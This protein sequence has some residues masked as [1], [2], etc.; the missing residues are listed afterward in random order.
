MNPANVLRDVRYAVRMLL[1]NPGF[2]TIALLTFAVGIGINTAVFSVFNGVLLRPLPYPD[3]ERITMM[4][5]DN[6][7]QG[8]KED[9]GSYPNY[10][11][12]REQN[13]TYEH[14]A[15]YT[16]ASM[17]MTGS[18][19]PERLS[20]AQTTANFFA[21]MGIQPV[22][23]RV[24]NEDQ[25]KV[26]NDAVVVLSHGLWQRKFGGTADV[27]GKTIVLNGRAHEIIGVMAPEL[28]LPQKTQLWKPLAVADSLRD[29]RS[30]FWLP[31]IGKLKPG[32]SVQQAQTEIGGIADRLEKAYPQAQ[33]G[34]GAYI[35]PIHKQL[36]GDIER[37]LIVLMAAVGCVLLI[38]CANLGNL[39]LGR[40]AA[41][42]KELA[43]RTALGARRGRLIRQIVTETFVIAIAGSILGL[44]LAFWATEFFV[45]LGGDA[46][47]RKEAIAI[48][49]RVLMFT[50][51]LA[52]VSALLAGL[53]P[54][55]QASR[56][57]VRDHL[58]EGGREGG[59]GGSRRTRSVLIAAEMA[60][61]FILLAGAGVLVRT[62]W[63]ME[64][65]DRGF[66]PDHV[67]V[68]TLSLP[69]T[70]FAG[71]AE[72]RGF[73]TRLL[74]R[75]R[76][77]P[78]VESAATATGI[79]QPLLAN[80]GI[81]T[82]EG[83]PAPPPGQQIEYP[84]ETVSPGF[85][86]TLKIQLA[87]GRFFT[88]QDDSTAPP[89]AIVNETFAKMSWPGQDPIGRRIRPG[90]DS[91]TAPWITIVGVI[92]D[93][94]RADLRRAVRP[95]IYG[96][97]LQRVPRTQM[98]IVRTANDPSQILPVI[99]REV[100]SM[101][102][103][104]PLFATGTLGEELSETLSQPRFRAVL[105]AGFAIIAMLLASIGIYG[106]TAHAVSQRT[107]EV[108]VRMALGAQRSD[109][110]LLMLRQHLRPALVGVA[111]GI[112]GA[113]ALGR[114]I[115]SMVYGVGA[116]DPITFVVM[117]VALLS[118]AFAA[119]L[120]PARRATR[121]DALVALRNH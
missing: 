50:L 6:R 4:W 15:A 71:P 12:W 46:I 65:V 3:A 68:M 49:A 85:F 63:T 77:L 88:S 21:V 35:V 24:F 66:D 75:V 98:L 19:E 95:E 76:T 11:D 102:P 119:C 51:V 25:E 53:I 89:V 57:A 80:S 14:V 47:P 91:S 27:I 55:V 13:T 110:L 73:Y 40:T 7:V 118:V 69:Q 37:S 116:T 101:N 45:S 61:A 31:V 94:R 56:A 117:G 96:S 10:R 1:R 60:L 9:I 29:Q 18:E 48:D 67:A 120:L 17:T 105:L 36:V 90:G 113:F 32:V 42:R 104:L 43:I 28:D 16:G 72:V 82:I 81:Y 86:E 78:G 115:Q 84:V 111:L 59:S 52:A 62:L 70:L 44:L 22:L 5:L 26:G 109:V 121:V 92:K 23:G 8:I 64:K 100:Q 93:V 54:A 38:A 41:R 83:K 107:Q 114:F 74:D 99:R 79:L 112:A 20:A 103:M 33:A 87:A 30:A 108:G 106:V 58:Q 97:G 39:M 34:F 2:T